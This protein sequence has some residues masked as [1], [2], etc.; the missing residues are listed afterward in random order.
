M[1]LRVKIIYSFPLI[2]LMLI[3]SCKNEMRPINYGKD[4]CELCR[5]TVMNPQY[6]AGLLT[7][8]GKVYT[9]D[10]G[11]CLVRYVKKNGINEMD[12]Y[13]MSDYN[14]PGSLVDATTAFYLQG[15]SIQSPMGGNLAS[16]KDLTSA[17]V[18]QTSLGG[19]ILSWKDLIK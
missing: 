18:A 12:Q 19:Q 9:F 15:D 16:F 6:A 3:G 8:K 10:A 7:S 14:K 13:F 2:L 5:M 11:E 1:K 17:K 4:N